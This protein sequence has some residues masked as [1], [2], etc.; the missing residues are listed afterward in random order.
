MK[1]SQAKEQR[2]LSVSLRATT[3]F[4]TDHLSTFEVVG[5]FDKS[6][7]S[8]FK[9]MKVAAFCTDTRVGEDLVMRVYC[10]DDNEWSFEVCVASS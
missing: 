8:V 3:R 10:F 1:I 7:L 9:R 2:I 6:S 5:R 4:K